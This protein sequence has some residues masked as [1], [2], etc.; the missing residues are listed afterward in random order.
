MIAAPTKGI[1]KRA[2]AWAKALGQGDVIEE[3]STV[4]GGSLPQ[5]TLPTWVLALAVSKP[6]N[7]AARLRKAS[8]PIIVRVSEDKVMLDPRTVFSEQEPALLEAVQALL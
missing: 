8:P 5:E 1:K 2:K 6:N 3:K 7:F 4:G